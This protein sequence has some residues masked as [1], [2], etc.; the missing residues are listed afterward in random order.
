MI[1]N[2][3]KIMKNASPIAPHPFE[4]TPQAPEKR[5]VTPIATHIMF[6]ASCLKDAKMELPGGR[7]LVFYPYL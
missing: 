6:L 4:Y 5:A 3:I 2:P 7:G 1:N